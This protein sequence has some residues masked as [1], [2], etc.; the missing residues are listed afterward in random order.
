MAKQSGSSRQ[1]SPLQ[2]ISAAPAPAYDVDGAEALS[3]DEHIQQYGTC[4]K[5]ASSTGLVLTTRFRIH[6]LFVEP[7]MH[8]EPSGPEMS[9]GS[10]YPPSPTPRISEVAEENPT[11]ASAIDPEC[12]RQ[13][14]GRHPFVY[15]S[16]RL[17][18][19][20]SDDSPRVLE[21]HVFNF[22]DSA[23]RSVVKKETP[24]PPIQSRPRPSVKETLTRPANPAIAFPTLETVLNPIDKNADMNTFFT[25]IEEA[26]A[27]ES[28]DEEPDDPTLPQTVDQKR[29]MV[30]ALFNAMSSTERAQDNPGMIKPFAE[31]KY[32]DVR[33]EVV[34][35]NILVSLLTSG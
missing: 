17:S 14:G 9:P 26:N 3:D 22:G 33:I 16:G 15:C 8:A 5:K 32:P 24:M 4:L 6:E 27:I 13:S 21:K 31:G 35:W 20:E 2:T 19:E 30:K 10:Q 7:E 11:D 28:P 1:Y 18:D 34:A 25:C 12:I 23:R 29:A